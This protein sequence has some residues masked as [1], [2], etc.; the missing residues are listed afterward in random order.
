[1][2][3]IYMREYTCGCEEEE[4]FV[5][6]EKRLG[7]NVRCDPVRE[8]ARPASMH[9]CRHHMVREGKDEMHSKA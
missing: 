2:C 7:T 6:C 8:I 5:Q 1:M 4:E 3:I 9:M